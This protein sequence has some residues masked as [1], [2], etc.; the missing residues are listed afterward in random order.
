[1]FNSEVPTIP[2]PMCPAVALKVPD[3]ELDLA[4]TLCNG[5][6][7]RWREC[8]P[9]QWFGLIE[10]RPVWV[11]HHAGLLQVYGLPEPPSVVRVRE[12]FDLATPMADILATFPA[13]DPAMQAA[14]Q[15]YAGMRLL[16]QDPWEMLMSFVLA[17][18]K[19]IPHI[20]QCIERLCARYGE[21]IPTG[22][23]GATVYGW[24]SASTL[25]GG[26][27]ADLRACALGYRAPYISALARMVESGAIDLVLPYSMRYE[28]AQRYL[29]QI[30]GIGPKVADC[31]LLF[32]YGHQEAFPIDVWIDRVLRRF[33]TG[34]KP[35]PA[36][37]KAAFV[38]ARF[39][40]YAGYAQQ[41]LFHWA[42]CCSKD[43]G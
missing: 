24:P 19:R 30:P 32:A 37:E 16:H 27:E 12:Y 20:Q 39:G 8:R 29:Q 15:A 43:W 25:A 11:T 3:E 40:P 28:E 26:T 41:Y 2:G 6:T 23:D 1:M 7:F 5:Q 31:V 42:R 4:Q 36:K 35:V 38:R 22:E 9:G 10:N 34:G 33:Y 21:P 13:A 17:S 14:V 18:N